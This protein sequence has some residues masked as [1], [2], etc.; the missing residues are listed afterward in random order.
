LINKKTISPILVFDCDP[1]CD[2]ALAIALVAQDGQYRKIELL[3][4]AGNVSVDQTTAN[5]C[6]LV[7]LLKMNGVSIE[8]SVHRDVAAV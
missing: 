5:A 4:V 1:G 8:M 3:T 2:D 6:R 7:E